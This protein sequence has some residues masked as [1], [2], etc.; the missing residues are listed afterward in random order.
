MDINVTIDKNL[1]VNLNERWLKLVVEETLSLANDDTDIELGLFITDDKTIKKLNT[2]YRG[3]DEPTDVLSFALLEEQDKFPAFTLPP[4]GIQHLG[5]VII[6]YPRALKQAEE[7]GHAA[8]REMAVLIIHGILHLL[9]YEHED[10]AREQE[11]RE[12]QDE[13]LNRLM[14]WS[15]SL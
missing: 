5:E 3:M 4:D 1:G 12:M 10:E 7:N 13:I 14:K 8:E 11:M 15:T 9:G 2:E 6:S